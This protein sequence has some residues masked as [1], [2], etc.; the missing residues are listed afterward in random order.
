VPILQRIYADE[1]FAI[2]DDTLRVRRLVELNVIE[3][4][5]NLYK[6]GG[7][8]SGLNQGIPVIHP[9]VFDPTTGQLIKLDADLDAAVKAL[10]NIYDMY[11]LEHA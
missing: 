2:K 4:C 1:L 10:G 7:G 8:P 3:Q 9:M 5:L 11:E 6:T